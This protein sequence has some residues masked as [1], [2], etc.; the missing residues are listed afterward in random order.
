MRFS[1][2]IEYLK[3]TPPSSN[4][5]EAWEHL[6]FQLL[7]AEHGSKGL[8]RL[9]PP[10][11]GIDILHRTLETAYQCKST[12]NG[13][14]GTIDSGPCIQSLDR[15]ITVRDT[16]QWQRLNYCLNA[17]L[18]GDGLNKILIHATSVGLPANCVDALGPGYWNDLCE[19][20]TSL[21]EGLF[22]Y[23]VFVSESQ[24]REALKK[25]RYFDSF[26][27]KAMQSIASDPLSLTITNNRCPAT[28]VLPFSGELTVEQLIDVAMSLY[29]VSLDWA[30]F[31]DLG[32]SCGP[33]ISLTT[34]TRA[35]PFNM[36]LRDLTPEQQ[37]KLQLWIKLVWKD[38]LAER[39]DCYDGE[40]RMMYL[41]TDTMLKREVMGIPAS[42]R[43]ELT[44]KRTELIFQASIWQS[45]SQLRTP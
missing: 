33:S 36:K 4:F 11:R 16:F 3:V 44:L 39:K 22:D 28:L 27:D 9:A 19:K 29:G 12:E 34:D 35:H 5:G 7:Q 24:V 15:A 30:N 32:T 18:T 38:S 6:C 45:L 37:T 17:P 21:I 31:P 43:G 40:Q 23:R 41:M 42:E 25:A 2:S 1:F 26:I 13:A 14:F 8:L 10:D 20:H